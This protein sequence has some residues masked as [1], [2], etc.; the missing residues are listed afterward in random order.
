[1]GWRRVN[2]YGHD[3]ARRDLDWLRGEEEAYETHRADRLLAYITKLEAKAERAGILLN[4]HS[5]FDLLDERDA[6]KAELAGV[7]AE[8]DALREVGTALADLSWNVQMPSGDSIEVTRDHEAMY[9]ARTEWRQ[10]V[11]PIEVAALEA[12]K[13]DTDE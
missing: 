10:L 4:P 9:R 13:G 8:R 3:D 6:L 7:T 5:G 11:A 2:D 12:T 1:M